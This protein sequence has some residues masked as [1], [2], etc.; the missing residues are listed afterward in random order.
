MNKINVIGVDL[1]KNVI[2]VVR[3]E[4]FRTNLSVGRSLLSFWRSSSRRSWHLKPAGQRT[5]G[6]VW[7]EATVMRRRYCR[8]SR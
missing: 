1:A 5:T 2:Q 6:R 8:R 4:S 3:I 7:R